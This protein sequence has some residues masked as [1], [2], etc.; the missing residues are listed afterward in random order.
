MPRSSKEHVASK[1]NP[2]LLLCL[3]QCRVVQ[4]NMSPLSWTHSFCSF[5]DY[6]CLFEAVEA[7]Y[8]K[9][10]GANTDEVIELFN[11]PN[12]TS[13]SIDLGL[14]QPL[15]EMS[16]RE[17]LWVKCERRIRLTASPPSVSRLSRKC[18]MIDISQTYSPPWPVTG[19]APLS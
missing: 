16:S 11:L 5:H 14:T 9:P 8:Y 19:I 10:E 2:Q 15:T 13:H 1:L 17:L 6:L 12:P 4:R 18:G 7:L 3:V